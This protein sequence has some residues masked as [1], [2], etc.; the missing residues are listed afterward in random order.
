MY[1]SLQN[2]ERRARARDNAATILHGDPAAA[3]LRQLYPSGM[4]EDTLKMS[5]HAC[6]RLS[7]AERA[8][9]FDIIEPTM[10]ISDQDSFFHWTQ[11]I[12]QRI[13]PHGK[14]LCG[15]GLPEKNGVLFHTVMGCNFPPEYLHTLQHPSGLTCT[16]ILLQWL[17]QQQPV[18]FEPK[19]DMQ[20]SPED[21]QW[22]QNFHRFK[23]LN[24]AAHGFSDN[25]NRTA[26]YFSFSAIPDP[27]TA[28]HSILLKLLVP[29]LHV[30][31]MRLIPAV[32]P[33]VP[34]KVNTP[35][36]QAID[37]SNRE[38]EILRWIGSGKTNWEIAQVLGLSEST[39]KNHIHRILHRINANSR[40]QAVVK[41]IELN[42]I[43]ANIAK[44]Q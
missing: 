21:G 24:I 33:K 12:L 15:Y 23:L 42:L 4:L 16:P 22:L 28:R 7:E 38:L 10:H 13:F 3:L 44:P 27:L 2:L 14:L 17:S 30:T 43:H 8:G 5:A 29:Y 36:Q 31:L 32:V 11:T 35:Q 26:S 40:T 9:F 6:V 34:P 39:V 25:H 37:L 41:A 1:D 19:P 20:I 18:L